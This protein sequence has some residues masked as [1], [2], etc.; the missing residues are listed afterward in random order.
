MYYNS[1]RNSAEKVTAAQAIAQGI[2]Q[3]GGLFV[4]ETLPELTKEDLTSMLGMS[5][6]EKAKAVLSRFLT[7][8]TPEELDYCVDN[9][10][11]DRKFD[12]ANIS[13]ISRVGDSAYL[14]QQLPRPT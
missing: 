14:Y 5:Y 1:T 6:N 8:F 13:E 9:A 7:D 12:S 4:P 10:Y 11:T 3:E 2:S